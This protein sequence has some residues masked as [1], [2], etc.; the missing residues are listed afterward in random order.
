MPPRNKTIY[1]ND[2]DYA[3][4]EE[5]KRMLA[6]YKRKTLSAFLTEKM[7]EYVEEERERQAGA[8]KD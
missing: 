2:Q 5:G 1:I 8:K 7:R 4:W 6:F 3:L